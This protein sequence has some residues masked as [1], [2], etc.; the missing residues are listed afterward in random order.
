M[1][2]KTSF[3]ILGLLIVLFA[4]WIFSSSNKNNDDFT[5]RV[6]VALRDAGHRLLL[7]KKDSTSLVLPV[8]K[9]EDY[10]YQLS[11]NEHLSFEPGVL[12]SVIKTSLDKAELSNFYSVE[13]KQC[14]DQEVAY[15]YQMKNTTEKSIIPCRGRI[16]PENCYNIELRFTKNEASSKIPIFLY[17]LSILAFVVLQIVFYKR[18]PKGVITQNLYNQ[19]TVNDKK[20][21]IG[22]F[23]FYPEQNK[24]V[25]AAVEISLS[26]IECELLSIFIEKPNQIIKRDEL[27]KKVWEDKGVI[28]GRSLDTYI[29]KLRKIFK[30]DASIKLT[31]VHG[32]GYK[33]EINR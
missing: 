7:T 9:L 23:Y 12:V 20:A 25:K 14:S 15:S 6:K 8:V 5:E 26:K 24:L 32:V 2:R 16:L 17:A 33:L 18:K 19:P 22:S 3:S 28:V 27:T 10:K 11:F 31:N 21:A 29:S 1:N 13:V 30:D 4:I